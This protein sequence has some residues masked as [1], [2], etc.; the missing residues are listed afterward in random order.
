MY[1]GKE[2]THSHLHI[3][4]HHNLTALPLHTSTGTPLHTVT[5][6]PLHTV[7][8]TPPHTVADTPPHTVTDTPLLFEI[9]L[10][11]RQEGDLCVC[12]FVILTLL[13]CSMFRY[14]PYSRPLNRIR[15]RDSHTQ[16][17]PIN[18]VLIN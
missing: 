2:S 17:V 5:D 3:K 10:H 6:T 12:V 15:K 7:T 14:N 8:G 18:M 9:H 1:T 4:A 16:Y 11:T 13:C